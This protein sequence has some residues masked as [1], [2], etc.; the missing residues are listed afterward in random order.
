[1]AATA[2]TAQDLVFDAEFFGHHSGAWKTIAAAAASSASGA[3]LQPHAATARIVRDLANL[4]FP[5]SVQANEQA[6]SEASILERIA[7]LGRRGFAKL[8]GGP[9]AVER[10]KAAQALEEKL[11]RNRKA[12]ISIM[13]EL[14]VTLT[15]EKGGKLVQKKID[16]QRQSAVYL[17][18]IELARTEWGPS[19]SYIRTRE[20]FPAT[21]NLKE[22]QLQHWAE[23]RERLQKLLV[24]PKT[25]SKAE[26]SEIRMILHS[27][28]TES[29]QNLRGLVERAVDEL[30]ARLEVTK[31]KDP[32]WS[33]EDVKK[34]PELSERAIPDSL[35][36]YSLY[37]AFKATVLDS[38]TFQAG[39]AGIPPADE[40]L[41]LPSDGFSAQQ[42]NARQREE[43][44]SPSDAA[45]SPTPADD[46][47]ASSTRRRRQNPSSVSP[48]IRKTI[49]ATTA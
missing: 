33:E 34:N 18:G 14:R 40:A 2:T 26:T 28:D 36:Q 47:P 35:R 32:F 13:E 46:H 25:R 9:G 29:R 19:A 6:F 4:Y 12:V 5:R 27:E 24:S 1:M 16:L 48:S 41:V 49:A 17:I 15:M 21:K 11:G 10:E 39:T 38:A 8:F 44:S 45:A 42:I 22:A 23:R 7:R 30:T 20:D 37:Y 31:H 43:S 3:K